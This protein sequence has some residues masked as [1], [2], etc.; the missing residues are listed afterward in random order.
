MLVPEG[1]SNYASVG[2]ESAG[3]RW[4]VLKNLLTFLLTLYDAPPDD[5]LGSAQ[6]HAQDA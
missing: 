6:T 1:D 4:R 3:S 5:S 2:A